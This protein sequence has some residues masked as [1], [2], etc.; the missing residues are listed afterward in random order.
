MPG[1]NDAAACYLLRGLAAQSETPDSLR[2]SSIHLVKSLMVDGPPNKFL[3]PLH[4]Y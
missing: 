3:L 4:K 2:Q 1:L